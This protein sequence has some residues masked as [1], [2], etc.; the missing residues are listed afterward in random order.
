MLRVVAGW[1]QRKIKA[2]KRKLES[3][4]EERGAKRL[5]HEREDL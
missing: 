1:E 2:K 5:H 3:Y 4:K